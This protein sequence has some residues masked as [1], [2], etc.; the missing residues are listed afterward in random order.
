MTHG[1]PADLPFKICWVP[2]HAKQHVGVRRNSGFICKCGQGSEMSSRCM[3]ATMFSLMEPS[4]LFLS[5][6]WISQP[7]QTYLCMSAWST[8]SFSQYHPAFRWFTFDKRRAFSCFLCCFCASCWPSF[9]CS[10]HC[11]G[12]KKT[13]C[14]LWAREPGG[15]NDNMGAPNTMVPK[16][17]RTREGSWGEP[18]VWIVRQICADKAG[19]R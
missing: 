1:T 12:A 17:G 4:T 15:E 7:H 5:C 10:I 8:L 18:G 9:V 16:Q 2:V 19:L 14:S 3:T 6:S 13:S 11:Q